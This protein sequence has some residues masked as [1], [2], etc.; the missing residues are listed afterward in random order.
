[1]KT[2][3]NLD[4]DKRHV[5]LDDLPLPLYD[6]LQSFRSEQPLTRRTGQLRSCQATP[7]CRLH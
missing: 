4:G 2:A 1:M 3:R 6:R 5:V 7:E